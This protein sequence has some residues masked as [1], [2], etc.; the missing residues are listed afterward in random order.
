MVFSFKYF[1]VTSSSSIVKKLLI[2]IC[3]FCVILTVFVLVKS[4]LMSSVASV[5]ML[6]VQYN[7][8]LLEFV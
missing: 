8:T 6:F 7:P 5:L 3:N 1:P 2:K 4:I